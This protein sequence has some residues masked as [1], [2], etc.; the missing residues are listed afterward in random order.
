MIMHDPTRNQR[1]LVKLIFSFR[2]DFLCL[3]PVLLGEKPY[4]YILLLVFAIDV[5]ETSHI[6]F[7]TIALLLDKF[8]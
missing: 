5:K 4:S 8:N 7:N 3:V 1:E 2:I 6:F